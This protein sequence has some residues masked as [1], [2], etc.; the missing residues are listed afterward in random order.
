MGTFDDLV[1]WRFESLFFIT[2]LFFEFFSF[3]NFLICSSE[4]KFNDRYLNVV[5]TFVDNSFGLENVKCVNFDIRSP[6]EAM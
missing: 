6:V 2:F 3:S 5:S 4:A 1:M